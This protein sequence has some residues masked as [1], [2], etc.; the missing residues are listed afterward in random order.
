LFYVYVSN[1]NFSVGPYKN[2]PPKGRTIKN[3]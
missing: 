2:S 1:A 3:C